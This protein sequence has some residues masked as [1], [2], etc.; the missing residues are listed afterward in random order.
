MGGE[1]DTFEQ[2]RR[3]F[4]DI[5][6]PGRPFP[7]M[8]EQRTDRLVADISVRNLRIGLLSRGKL[9][10]YMIFTPE[11]ISQGDRILVTWP[12]LETQS[13]AEAR[14]SVSMGEA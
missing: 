4:S 5:K 6:E 9:E 12:H 8:K 7:E 13:I 1:G 10:R 3:P 14:L 2:K 11:H